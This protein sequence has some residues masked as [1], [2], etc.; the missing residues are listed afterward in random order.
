ML[1]SFTPDPSMVV[2]HTAYIPCE[3]VPCKA[4]FLGESCM[5]SYFPWEVLHDGYDVTHRGNNLQGTPMQ[6]MQP[7]LP[8][9]LSW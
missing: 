4:I 1:K 2:R 5:M 9:N 3:D 7:L 6:E 8:L